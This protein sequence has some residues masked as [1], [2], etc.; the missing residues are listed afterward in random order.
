MKQREDQ[1]TGADAAGED[2]SMASPEGS[3][4]LYQAIGSKTKDLKIYPGLFPEI[5]NEPEREQVF[6]DMLEWL[7]TPVGLSL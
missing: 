2:D 4:F 7:K 1:F 3:R 6:Q 5:F